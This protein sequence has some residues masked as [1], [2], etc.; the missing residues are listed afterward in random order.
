[1]STP[2]MN[3]P[4][5]W[6]TLFP[7]ALQLM[8][9]LESVTEDP[10]W[11]FGGGTVLMLRLNHRHSKDIDLFVPDPQYLGYVNPR[12]SDAAEA[13]SGDY[14]AGAL[15]VKLILDTG[16]IDVVV[17]P[18]LTDPGHELVEF[19][20]R[21][22]RVETSAEVITKKMW[23][24]GNEGNARDLFD[25]CTV[26]R[27]EPAAIEKARP[28]FDKHGATFIELLE[29]N[30]DI[31]KREFQAIMTIGDAPDFEECLAIARSI[32]IPPHPNR[33]KSRK[34]GR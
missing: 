33:T 28:F 16:E 26:A 24:R 12:I 6:R 9:H 29:S 7:R 4:G 13:I 20:G 15:Y 23:H 2:D 18:P 27:A 10:Q 3:R 34:P 19:E 8:D 22:L 30:G 1:M 14:R 25:L 31:A 21:Q 17:G 11:T 32:L 5:P